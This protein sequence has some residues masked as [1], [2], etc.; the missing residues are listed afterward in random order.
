META[1]Y[2][3][4]YVRANVAACVSAFVSAG[5]CVQLLL[6]SILLIPGAPLFLRMAL[7]LAAV[8]KG[9]L[10]GIGWKTTETT[11]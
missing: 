5:I 7:F 8:S 2:V 4:V 9:Q 10:F 6:T 1:M 3:C 11:V